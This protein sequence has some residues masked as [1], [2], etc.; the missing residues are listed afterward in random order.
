[1]VINTSP[2]A[3]PPP[4]IALE[5][6]EKVMVWDVRN[7]IAQKENAHNNAFKRSNSCDRLETYN[8]LGDSSSSEEESDESEEMECL[9]MWD[10]DV[11]LNEDESDPHVLLKGGTEEQQRESLLFSTQD[12]KEQ[13]HQLQYLSIDKT[14]VW[15]K[16]KATKSINSI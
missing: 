11:A 2:K 8:E 4:N 1:M 5:G 9:M 12:L 7:L 13:Y 3:R 6:N 14:I 16:H 10:D 15:R